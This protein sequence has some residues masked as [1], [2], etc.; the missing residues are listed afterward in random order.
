MFTIKATYTLPRIPNESQLPGSI[1]GWHELA[2]WSNVRH[3]RKWARKRRLQKKMD[4]CPGRY[5]PD[6]VF[7]RY[8]TIGEKH[9]ED[10]YKK[11]TDEITAEE[12][13]RLLELMANTAGLK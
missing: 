10:I 11:A 6:W 4:K 3:K 12:D 13:K 7:D 9:I 2:L 1:R 8:L 5:F